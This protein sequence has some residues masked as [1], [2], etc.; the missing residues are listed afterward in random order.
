M[1]VIIDFSVKGITCH[2]FGPPV[3]N[4]ACTSTLRY[5]MLMFRGYDVI[6]WLLL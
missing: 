4:R 3:R 5:A 2:F 6:E 1:A